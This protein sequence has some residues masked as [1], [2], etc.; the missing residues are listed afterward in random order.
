MDKINAVGIKFTPELYDAGEDV[1]T[2][3]LK[4]VLP[5]LGL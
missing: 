1:A 2:A 4:R 3:Y 5:Q